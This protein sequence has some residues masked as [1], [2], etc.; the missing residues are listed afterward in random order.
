MSLFFWARSRAC[1]WQLFSR[2]TLYDRARCERCSANCPFVQTCNRRY[3]CGA[4]RS[5]NPLTKKEN[6]DPERELKKHRSH[7]R[8][9]RK[10]Q[11]VFG[12]T[13]HHH[14]SQTAD[15]FWSVLPAKHTKVCCSHQH[16][17]VVQKTLN[18]VASKLH[19]R[20]SMLYE[21]PHQMPD[22]ANQHHH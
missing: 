11:F 20:P 9:A 10:L 4:S 2:K 15:P 3:L 7:K 19:I 8:K 18:R 13:T 16:T 6:T 22:T 1:V 12:R 5:V 14:L 17:H 21:R